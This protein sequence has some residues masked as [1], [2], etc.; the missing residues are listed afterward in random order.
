M[1]T[2]H[3]Q[4]RVISL[5]SNTNLS[6][7]A[8]SADKMDKICWATTDSTSMLILLNSSKQP[9]AP[10]CRYRDKRYTLYN[11]LLMTETA[12]YYFLFLGKINVILHIIGYSKNKI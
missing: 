7:P 4:M 6:D 5:P 3:D 12:K 10:V 1:K 8:A 9:Q 2:P 11:R